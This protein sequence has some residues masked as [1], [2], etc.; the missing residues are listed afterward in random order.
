LNRCYT[1][2]K[3]DP[4]SKN[5]GICTD[6]CEKVGINNSC[7]DYA[8]DTV[9]EKAIMEMTTKLYFYTGM[10]MREAIEAAIEFHK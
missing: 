2:K 6:T 8:P 5:M 4:V 3:F 7:I 1:C 9:K 10:N